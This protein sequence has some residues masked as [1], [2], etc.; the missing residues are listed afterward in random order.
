[1]YELS[2][3]SKAWDCWDFVEHCRVWNP[4]EMLR[5]IQEEINIIDDMSSTQMC[6]SYR[7]NIKPPLSSTLLK[8]G[9]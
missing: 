9:M 5:T 8:S 7:W 1:M 6:H 4:K 3:W 2:I